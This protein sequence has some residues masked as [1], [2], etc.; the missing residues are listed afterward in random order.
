ML[1]FALRGFFQG[2][3][4]QI[5]DLIGWVLGIG[6]C[7]SVSRWVGAYWHGARPVVIFAVLGW[8]V[9]VLAGLAVKAF[10]QMWGERLGEG[11]S[12]SGAGMADR[13]GG[14]VVGGVM[15]AA[16]VAS[17]LVAMLLTPWPREAA[18]TAA[19]SSLT[20][21]LLAGAQTV[22]NVDTRWIP[23]GGALKGAVHEAARR[24]R[25]LSRQS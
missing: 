22:L 25:E 16:L 4:R 13:I 10:F 24:A 6:C 19:H 1:L 9:A 5:V 23:G 7:I 14:L 12:K 3:L 21:S 11:A 2:T 8:L 17:L 18:R 15:G 20:G